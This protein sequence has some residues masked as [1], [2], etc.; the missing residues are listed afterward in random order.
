MNNYQQALHPKQVRNKILVN[1]DNITVDQQYEKGFT[2]SWSEVV[3]VQMNFSA[4]RLF[5]DSN[6]YQEFDSS[7][8]DTA[9]KQSLRKIIYLIA[10]EKQIP[11]EIPSA[12]KDNLL[13]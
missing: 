8:L 13:Q 7:K 6:Q 1:T 9:Q 2:L 5:T 10:Q 4:I 12:I 3:K 11:I